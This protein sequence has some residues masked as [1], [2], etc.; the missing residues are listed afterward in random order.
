MLNKMSITIIVVS[1][2][3]KVTSPNL[4]YNYKVNFVDLEIDKLRKRTSNQKC[5]PE[6][7]KNSEPKS[8]K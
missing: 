2:K 8:S 6:M 5:T 4:Q 3:L 1:N 7:G